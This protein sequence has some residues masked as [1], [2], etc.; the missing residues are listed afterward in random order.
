MNVGNAMEML[1]KRPE[2]VERICCWLGQAVPQQCTAPAP[3]PA[4]RPIF[5]RRLA[6]WLAGRLAVAAWLP[7]WLASGCLAG[8]R[9]AGWRRKPKAEIGKP[10]AGNRNPKAGN[11]KPKAEGR[12]PKVES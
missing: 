11:Q 8:W 1:F 5:G 9:L 4:A 7:G 3:A 6:A 2:K 12:K 10:K